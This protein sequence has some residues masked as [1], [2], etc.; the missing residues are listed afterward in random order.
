[1]NVEPLISAY[2]EEPLFC[3]LRR[4]VRP[5]RTQRGIQASGDG[6]VR[7]RRTEPRLRLTLLGERSSGYGELKYEIHSGHSH[8]ISWV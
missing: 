8:S 3:V 7:L 2:I 5:R 4:S 1:M 6:P